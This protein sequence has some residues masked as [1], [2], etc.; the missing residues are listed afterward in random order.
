VLEQ[1]RGDG[2]G[3]VGAELREHGRD[4]RQLLLERTEEIEGGG[5]WRQRTPGN[6]VRRAR[7][8][9]RRGENGRAGPQRE[10]VHDTP[11]RR[12]CSARRTSSRAGG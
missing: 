12:R 3:E 11:P 2:A 7:R 4:E 8:W 10:L 6:A 1:D 9:P 5:L